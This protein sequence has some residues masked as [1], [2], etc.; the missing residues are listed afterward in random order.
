MA[1]IIICR[2]RSRNRIDQCL[3]ILTVLVRI[4]GYKA[5]VSTSAR[6][7]LKA[8]TKDINMITGGMAL[9]RFITKREAGIVESG[10]KIGWRDEECSIMLVGRQLIKGNGKQIDYKATELYTTKLWKYRPTKTI[11]RTSS[12]SRTTGSNTRGL[13]RMI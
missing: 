1:F 2:L 4:R 6:C 13:S 12:S 10:C 7:Q 8:D 3:C 9:G 5:S 11:I